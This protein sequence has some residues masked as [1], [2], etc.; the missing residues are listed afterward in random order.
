MQPIWGQQIG[1][2]CR[3]LGSHHS[4]HGG[5]NRQSRGGHQLSPLVSSFGHGD[6]PLGTPNI[7][8]D[9]KRKVLGVSS[10]HVQH[11]PPS[12][13]PINPI[14]SPQDPQK[15]GGGCGRGSLDGGPTYRVTVGS[16]LGRIHRFWGST[17]WRW[18]CSSVG[19]CRRWCSAAL[20]GAQRGQIGHAFSDGHTHQDPTHLGSAR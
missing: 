9:P 11:V 20:D 17:V 4:P 18:C 6:T 12:H 15:L 2:K 10:L 8:R 1:V 3:D 19:R 5:C 16:H 13:S 14:I 7:I